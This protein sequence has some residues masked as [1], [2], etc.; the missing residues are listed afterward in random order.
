MPK[1]V[2]SVR[3]GKHIN[4]SKEN[5]NLAISAFSR[6][7][8]GLNPNRDSET[9]EDFLLAAQRKLPQEASYTRDKNRKSV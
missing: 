4:A 1:S 5:A 8:I 9:V 3:V 7:R 6:L 2:E